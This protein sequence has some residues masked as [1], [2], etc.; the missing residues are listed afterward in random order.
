M[1]LILNRSSLLTAVVAAL[2]AAACGG[3]GALQSPLSPTA[4]TEST[5]VLTGDALQASTFDT[6]ITA[7]G[8]G[9][10]R[11]GG[12]D[13]QKGR[14]DKG[15]SGGGSGSDDGRERSGDREPPRVKV[16]LSG[17]V[18]AVS[19][20]T[21]T[22]RGVEV[23]LGASTVIRHGSRTLTLADIRVGNHAQVKGTQVGGL[24]TATE[25][26]VEDTR[27]D[28]EDDDDGLPRVIVAGDDEAEGAIS[29]PSGTCPTL[30][31]S[32]GVTPVTTS[33][34][35]VFQGVTCA[36]IAAGVV[37]KVD[38]AGTRMADGSLAA[39][40]VELD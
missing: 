16:S 18:T 24:I 26:K 27:R 28:D 21:L 37:V 33:A 38:V 9:G 10:S 6:A 2:F 11:S 7:L 1:S 4:V 13:E 12:D 35:T 29:V 19:V 25:V 34:T 17:F 40:V 3:S 5:A 36:Q 15:K 32:V 20:S 23:A 22:V 31:F 14:D 8:K 30:A 39:A